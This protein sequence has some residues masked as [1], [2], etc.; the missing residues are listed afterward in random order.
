MRCFDGLDGV[1]VG[2]CP[3][4]FFCAAL[5][6]HGAVETCGVAVEWFAAEAAYFIYGLSVIFGLVLHRE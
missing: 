4:V 6:A 5:A 1:D 3:A 2:H